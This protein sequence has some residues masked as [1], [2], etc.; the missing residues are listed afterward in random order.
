MFFFH[1][2]LA[3]IVSFMLHIF[4][5]DKC[6]T[7]FNISTIRPYIISSSSKWIHLQSG[8]SIWASRTKFLVRGGFVYNEQLF[9]CLKR[10]KNWTKVMIFFAPSLI[11]FFIAPTSSNALLLYA[12]EISH[13]PSECFRQP[14]RQLRA[15]WFLTSFSKGSILHIYYVCSP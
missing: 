14:F 5:V 7:K 10:G 9:G 1:S 3:W 2:H 12:D 11:V 13:S 15:W 6:D 8:N 4:L